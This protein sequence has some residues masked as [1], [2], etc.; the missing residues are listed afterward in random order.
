MA[1]EINEPE[2]M[3]QSWDGKPIYAKK[4]ER[5]VNGNPLVLTIENEK[6]TAIGGISV[7]GGGEPVDAYTKEETNALLDD[8]V[9]KVSGKGLSA[10]DYTN[11]D[12]D[13][14]DNIESGAEVN[15]IAS[16]KVAGSAL[17]IDGKSVNVPEAGGTSGAWVK[18]VVSGEDTARWNSWVY[19]SYN[20][21]IAGVTINGRKYPVVKIGNLLWMA[22]NLDYQW[23]GLAASYD[24]GSTTEPR[25]NYYNNDSATYGEAGNKYGLLY[26]RPAA[27]YLEDHKTELGIPVGWRVPTSTDVSALLNFAGTGGA[28]IKSI[29]GWNETE[30]AGTNETGF[31]LYP[32]GR[33]YNS[34]F[35]YVGRL[36]VLWTCTDSTSDYYPV[37]YI[38]STNCNS[39]TQLPNGQYGIR[40]VKTLS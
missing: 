34:S 17:A 37:L 2:E 1:E 10:N 32:T 23:S 24:Y 26:N 15:L 9:D 19:A 30:W 35:T 21:P 3:F 22:E 29:D 12:K 20:V 11:A 13:K 28:K 36:S 31:N 39:G 33:L 8:K 40:L 27:K 14:L 25:A 16:V 6:V 38:E 4:A 18:G 7:G 5:D